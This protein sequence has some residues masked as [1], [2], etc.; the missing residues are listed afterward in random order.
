VIKVVALLLKSL[1]VPHPGEMIMRR[2]ASQ[3][4]KELETRVARLEGKSAFI[5]KQAH[6]HNLGHLIKTSN[7][8][9]KIE[10]ATIQTVFTG[11]AQGLENTKDVV[12]KNFSKVIKGLGVRSPEDILYLY[13]NMDK[14]INPQN[15]LIR[16]MK[17]RVERENSFKGRMALIQE[18]VDNYDDRDPLGFYEWWS[19][20]QADLENVG[21]YIDK[22]NL[23]QFF[24][25]ALMFAAANF[26]PIVLGSK[27][28][29]PLITLVGVKV[30]AIVISA[31]LAIKLLGWSATSL[32]NFFF[33]HLLPLLMRARVRISDLSSLLWSGLK[34]IGRG[35]VDT[36][37]TG[38]SKLKSIFSFGSR[39]SHYARTLY[40]PL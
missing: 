34:G 25:Y 35:L 24:I 8:A 14:L 5:N 33:K 15:P 37:N 27:A 17:E 38:V 1:C 21:K 18:M 9:D 4:I 36:F 22:H 7:Q 29:G 19:Q 13:K 2:T 40:L 31:Y 39:S 30:I 28:L 10:K 20:G 26:W 12:P 6:T 23:A 16:Q 11:F 32:T 3:V